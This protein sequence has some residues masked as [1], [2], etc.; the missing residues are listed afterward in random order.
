[1]GDRNRSGQSLVVGDHLRYVEAPI[2]INVAGALGGIAPPDVEIDFYEFAAERVRQLTA[3]VPDGLPCTTYARCGKPLTEIQSI[4]REMAVGVLFVAP[5]TLHGQPLR[6]A[7][8][9][10]STET[11]DGHGYQLQ[12]SQHSA[13]G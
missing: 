12:G 7:L 6:R 13:P 8:R 10:L 1:M 4:L 2:V 3:C 5:G 11:D 9:H